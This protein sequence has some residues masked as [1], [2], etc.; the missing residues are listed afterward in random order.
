MDGKKDIRRVLAHE[1][2]DF[3]PDTYGE[4][5]DSERPKA[6]NLSAWRIGTEPWGASRAC[7]KMHTMANGQSGRSILLD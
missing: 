1:R 5:R 6:S 3:V 4:R 2:M 7:A